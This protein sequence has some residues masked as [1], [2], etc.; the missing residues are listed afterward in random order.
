MGLLIDTMEGGGEGGSG[1]ASA[2]VC[3]CA[4]EAFTSITLAVTFWFPSTS[5]SVDC[6][7]GTVDI[8]CKLFGG[9]FE[10]SGESLGGCCWHSGSALL[11]GMGTI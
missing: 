11:S 4:C 2:E 8:G 5:P 6:E 7:E 9:V 1:E 10:V 3:L